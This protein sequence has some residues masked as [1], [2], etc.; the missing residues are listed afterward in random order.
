[1]NAV[2]YIQ[3]KV[4]PLKLLEYYGF[5]EIQEYENEIRACC[6]IHKGNN[7]N[8]FI[9]NK[10]NNLW[11][12]YTGDNCGGGDTVELVRKMEN[13]N[14][15][16]AV[17]K[18]AQI[19]NLNIEGLE[20]IR[21]RDDI[22]REHEKWLSTQK[23]K[24]KKKEEISEYHLPFTKYTDFLPSFKRF[25]EETLNFYGAKFCTLFPLEES[26]LK[27]KLVIPMY[28]G[29]VLRGV[30]LRDT[31]GNFNPKW[32]Y[33]PKGFKASQYLYNIDRVLELIEE[34]C[35][36]VILVEGIFDVWSFHNIGI[37]NV[38]AVFGS[39]ISKEQIDTLL[40]LNVTLTLCFDN[41]NAGN[42]C[43]TKS[44]QKLKNKTELKI[45]EL[46]LESDPGDC[47]KE[48]LLSAYLNRKTLR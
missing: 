38:V 30:A 28:F 39:N 1:M 19:L 41:D 34:G 31:T 9:W 15:Q 7:R 14:F 8:A 45:I 35:D 27:E 21:P 33:M 18:A 25:S 24:A 13:L 3:E 5:R 44:I 22:R 12:C 47:S 17:A 23:E 10:N 16:S 32:M 37:E 36:E 43:T 42:K 48:T 2:E 46:P 20:I 26:V 40:R 4:N 29:G 6:E 11:Y